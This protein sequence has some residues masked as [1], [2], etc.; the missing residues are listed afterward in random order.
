MNSRLQTYQILTND[1]QM[2]I[3]RPCYFIT[4]VSSY[5]SGHFFQTSFRHSLS[6]RNIS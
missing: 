3:L 5:A 1:D 6:N 2:L 4:T